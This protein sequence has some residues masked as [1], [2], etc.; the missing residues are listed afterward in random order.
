MG[1]RG[2]CRLV[3]VW[4]VLPSHMAHPHERLAGTVTEYRRNQVSTDSSM[5]YL[6]T[7]IT[8]TLSGLTT[9]A[10]TDITSGLSG[11]TSAV[12]TEITS[13]V[14]SAEELVV[15]TFA[16][17]SAG[18]KSAIQ[19]WGGVFLNDLGDLDPPAWI[20]TALHRCGMDWPGTKGSTVRSLANYVRQFAST[21]A[22][23][24]QQATAAV[25]ACAN[26]LVSL[27][28]QSMLAG[29]LTLK[30]IH[31]DGLVT[32]CQA[33]ATALDYVSE[34]IPVLKAAALYQIGSAVVAGAGIIVAN[35]F[36]DG[37]TVELDAA[38]EAAVIRWVG[39]QV[40]A[41]VAKIMTTVIEPRLKPAV[42]QLINHVNTMAKELGWDKIAETV[43]NAGAQIESYLQNEA[44]AVKNLVINS[45]AAKEALQTIDA[46][47]QTVHEGIGSVLAGLQTL[48]F[49]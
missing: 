49:G 9:A 34:T 27:T 8:S 10:S 37:T 46:L 48:Q 11:L 39:G 44:G 23:L 7:E 20:K 28:G 41:L 21:V 19:N 31:I 2:F 14:S 36:T 12:G 15:S 3:A 33:L 22:E 43:K 38:A 40:A 16:Q 25:Q 6:S 17:L 35:V 47:A 26:V 32:C 45:A 13:I 5:S 18:I 30:G 42:Q 1:F 29:W 4:V 24:T